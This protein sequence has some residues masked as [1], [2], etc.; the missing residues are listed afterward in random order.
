MSLRS[1]TQRSKPFQLFLSLLLLSFFQ[2]Q[3]IAQPK[4][5]SQPEDAILFR[6][7]EVLFS[8]GETEKALWRFKRLM[9]EYPNSPLTNE[10]KFRMGVCYTQLK[11]PSD[12]IRFLTDLFSGFLSPARMFQVFTLLGDNYVELKDFL[13]ALQWYGKGL[14]LSGQP[15]DR[16]KEKVRTIIDHLAPE[17]EIHRVESLY[18]GAYAGGYAKLRL[19][20]IARGRG[21]EALAKRMVSELEAEYKGMDFVSQARELM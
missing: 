16:L 12:A 3:A 4:P 6:E 8:K 13:S 7:G 17:E 15:H 1:T 21:N 18:R 14:L 20:R 19:A 11:R 5:S 2:S 10:A 9:T